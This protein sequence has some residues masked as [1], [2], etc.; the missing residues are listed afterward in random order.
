[1]VAGGKDGGV[2]DGHVHTAIFKVDIQQ[3]P[4]VK[5]RE[6]CSVMWQP[7]WEGS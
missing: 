3:G 5:F 2:W 4:T 6:L 1:M 7:G